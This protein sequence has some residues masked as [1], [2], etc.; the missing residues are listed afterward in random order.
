MSLTTDDLKMIVQ[1]VSPLIDAK[2]ETLRALIKAD[3]ESSKNELR[4]QM[5]IDIETAKNELKKQTKAD[6]QAAKS[7]LKV[8]LTIEIQNFRADITKKTKSNDKRLT[9]IEEEL[10]IPHP[11]KN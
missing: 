11:D 1:T 8:E 7:E 10:G 6:I 2:N 9:T 4:K 5:K 3:I